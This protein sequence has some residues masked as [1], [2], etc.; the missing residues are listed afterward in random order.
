MKIII[1]DID[2]TIATTIGTKYHLSK[3]IKSQ[4]KKINKLY[5]RGYI[6]KIF[7]ARYMGKHNGNVNLIKKKY[8]QK[9][10]NQI[11]NWG[12]KFHELIMGKPIF[13]LFIDDKAYNVRDKNLDKILNKII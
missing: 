4:I 11:T 9:T 5:G 2:N 3:P 10:Y 8:Y 7:T 12:L 13:D 1:F 6:I